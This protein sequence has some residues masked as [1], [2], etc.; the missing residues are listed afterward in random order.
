[1]GRVASAYW[2]RVGR[3]GS[4]LL[5]FAVLDLI[6]GFSLFNP[7]PTAAANPGFVFIAGIA[8]LR[9]WGGL[10]LAVGLVCLAGAFVREDSFAWAAAMALK[11]L[12]GTVFLCG[13]LLTGLER[14]YVSAAIWLCAAALVALLGSWPE[15]PIGGGFVWSRRRP[16]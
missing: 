14:G 11:V 4:A 8:P 7:T 10:W 13:W 9:V 16:G 12:W 3:R 2:R 1:M 5:F 6:Y 15:P